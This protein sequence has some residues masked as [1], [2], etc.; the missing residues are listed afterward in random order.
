[1][2]TDDLW[3]LVHLVQETIDKDGRP[4][5]VG[6]DGDE[7]GPLAALRKLADYIDPENGRY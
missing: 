7:K 3:R 6:M 2:S 1:M 4:L 5:L